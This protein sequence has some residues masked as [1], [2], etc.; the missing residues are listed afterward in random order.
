MAKLIQNF[1]VRADRAERLQE[2]SIEMTIEQKERITES[3][4]IN[5]LIDNYM[6]EVTKITK[7]NLTTPKVEV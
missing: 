2:L 6:H 7:I 4:I 3:D 1:R 5:H